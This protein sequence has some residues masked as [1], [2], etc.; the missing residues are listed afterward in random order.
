MKKHPKIK[1]TTKPYKDDVKITYHLSNGKLHRIDGPAVIDKIA[2]YEYNT[3]TPIEKYNRINKI[4]EI[5]G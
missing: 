5:L 3:T 1:T 2:Q 4:E